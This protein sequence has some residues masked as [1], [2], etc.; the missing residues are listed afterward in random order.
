MQKVRLGSILLLCTFFT[1]S[2]WAVINQVRVINNTDE[3]IDLLIGGYLPAQKIPP[4]HWRVLTYPFTIKMPDNTQQKTGL[5]VVTAGGQ[6]I[7]T[8]A[9]SMYL[10]DPK[11]VQ[12]VDYSD[13]ENKDLTGD[14][15]WKIE[16]LV[17]DPVCYHDKLKGLL[18]KPPS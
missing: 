8:S 14:R 9:G 2:T 4:K 17:V 16:G 7:T 13:N 11:M 12:C 15:F 10:Q 1:T 5:L 3:A 6:W 18:P